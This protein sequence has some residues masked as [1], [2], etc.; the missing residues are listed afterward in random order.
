M[1]SGESAFVSRYAIFCTTSCGFAMRSP[2]SSS[3]TMERS[4]GSVLVVVLPATVRRR[5]LRTMFGLLTNNI[6]SFAPYLARQM[7][8]ACFSKSLIAFRKPLKKDC[9]AWEG[10]D[11]PV[12]LKVLSVEKA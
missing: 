11:F 12:R 4:V 8:R 5:D 1:G 6:S 3:L 7:V 9:I 2:V 10:G